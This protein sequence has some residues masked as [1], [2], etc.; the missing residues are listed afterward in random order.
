[1]IYEGP[2]KS[3]VIKAFDM[4]SSLGI[5]CVINQYREL[6]FADTMVYNTMTITP[7]FIVKS[8]QQWWSVIGTGH[9][10]Y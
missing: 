2:S 1:M 7:L 8:R 3:N 4:D 6:V 5:L 9:I 10:C